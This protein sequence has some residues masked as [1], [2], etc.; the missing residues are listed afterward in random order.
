MTN[1]E[2][3]TTILKQ[4]TESYEK[5]GTL[6]EQKRQIIIDRDLDALEQSANQEQKLSDELKRL[7]R[8]RI[9]ILKTFTDDADVIPTV[10]DVVNALDAESAECA[11][12]RKARDAIL[13]AAGQVQFLNSQNE[14]LLQQA[15]EM[16]E[17]D[18]TLFKSL[19]QA[20][21][22][23]NYGK[24]AYSTGELLP[25]GGFDAKQ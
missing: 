24:D 5:L 3:L 16:V 6:A 4:E 19:R 14:V 12:L 20:P 7:E 2:G 25:S 13:A 8:Q 1:V 23:G 18:L 21:E 15:M 22:S 10:S 9:D 17:F 11:A